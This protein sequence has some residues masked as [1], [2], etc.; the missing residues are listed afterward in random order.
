M[1]CPLLTPAFHRFGRSA[2]VL[3][4]ALAVAACAPPRR[5]VYDE[6]GLLFQDDFSQEASGWDRHRDSLITTDYEDGRYVIAVE[7][8]AQNVWALANLDLTDLTLAVD[9]TYAAGPANNE[10]GVI[11][12]YTRS[13][14]RHS[15]YFFFISSD[16]Y[17]ASGKVVSNRRTILNPESGDFQPASAIVQALS[18]TNRI[19]ATCAG[20]RLSFAVNGTDLGA[21]EDPEL[22]HGDIGLIVGTFDEGGVKIYFDNLVVRQP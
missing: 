20:R 16:G 6:P 4:L 10:F 14:D 5:V 8:V 12:R 11:C 18:A 15:F 7:D 19:T 22:T 21:F 1:G 3:G 2:A 13:G 9:A 17:Y